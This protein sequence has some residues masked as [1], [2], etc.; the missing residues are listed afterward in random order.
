MC[1][2]I[3]IPGRYKKHA[4]SSASEIA[5]CVN[6]DAINWIHIAWNGVSPDSIRKCFAM[7][8]FSVDPPLIPTA[9]PTKSE[10]HNTPPMD[11]HGLL[12]DVSWD[13]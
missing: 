13:G 11:Y 7:C 4:V 1:R 6:P 10:D 8:G 3:D 12:R 2:I 5:K 9:P